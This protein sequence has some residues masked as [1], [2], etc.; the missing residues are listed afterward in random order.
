MA[1]AHF[2]DGARAAFL[3]AVP[4]GNSGAA[5][6]A[7]EVAG[8]RSDSGTAA[9]QEEGPAS[10]AGE[11]WRS[12][13]KGHIIAVPEESPAEYCLDIESGGGGGGDELSLLP[14][15]MHA[16]GDVNADAGGR[17]DGSP[18]RPRADGAGA[19]SPPR[20]PSAATPSP[21]PRPDLEAGDHRTPSRLLR[22]GAPPPMS[23]PSAS[24]DLRPR[25]SGRFRTGALPLRRVSWSS[26][27]VDPV[28]LPVKPPPTDVEL[29]VAQEGF[30]H[31]LTLEEHKRTEVDQ[32]EA[33]IKMTRVEIRRAV[34]AEPPTGGARAEE[35]YEEL[36]ACAAPVCRVAR[37]AAWLLCVGIYADVR[38]GCCLL[39][40][41]RSAERLCRTRRR[42]C[43]TWG[44]SETRRSA[45]SRGNAR[46][47]RRRA[48]TPPTKAAGPR[49]RQLSQERTTT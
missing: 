28:K 27:V 17:G 6:A 40:W 1:A 13:A 49:G 7:S 47:G 20:T 25:G 11:V 4:N 34:E 41:C 18:V 19:D 16:N 45:S 42:T 5:E 14:S 43:S 35:L 38:W 26:T 37:G 32:L 23:C 2:S 24:A 30:A 8:N 3:A 31:A 48:G 15:P 21:P 10:T 36:Q 33:A 12:Y 29:Y 39:C 46:I 44:C 9:P 22:S